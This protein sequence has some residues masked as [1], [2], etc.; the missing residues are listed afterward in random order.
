ML[1]ARDWLTPD[2]SLFEPRLAT[3]IR[4]LQERV[5]ERD[6]LVPRCPA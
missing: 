1:G 5:D 3:R 4:T 2:A 6:G